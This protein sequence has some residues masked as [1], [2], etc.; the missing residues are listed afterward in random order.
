[1]GVG[2]DVGIIRGEGWAQ[3]MARAIPYAVGLFPLIVLEIS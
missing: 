2:M 1:M 3:A